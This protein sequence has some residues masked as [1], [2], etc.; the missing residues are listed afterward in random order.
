[1]TID[2]LIDARNRRVGKK[3]NGT[4]TQ[5]FL[6]QDQLNPIAELDGAGNVTARF[7]Y[8]D[9]AHV[10]AYMQKG[11][12]TYR[13]ISDHLGS[14]RL[15]IDT[16]TGD[17]AQRLDYDPW[18][19]ITLDTNPGFQPFGFAGGL[20]DV[21]TGLVR[22]GAREYDPE[23]GR[24]TAKD[25]ILFDG[26]DANL[27]GYVLGDSINYIDPYGLLFTGVHAF[28]RGVTTRQAMQAGEAGNAAAVAGG[29]AAAATTGA[30]AAILSAPVVA[31]TAK[32]AGVATVTHAQQAAILC[33]TVAANPNVQNAVIDF[34][35][36]FTVPGPPP[37]SLPGVLGAQVNHA[38][39]RLVPARSAQ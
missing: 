28:S 8:A 19:R 16:A 4:L 31:A 15:V 29:V 14:P 6:Y 30:A 35:S 17:I 33:T 3:I 27:Y 5:G 20:H 26:G 13:I 39:G 34:V 32:A 12:A 9:N 23:T 7:I 38:I 22:F 37:M 11:G 10:P 36:G 24:W 1:M 21:H 25:P 18:G 2:Y